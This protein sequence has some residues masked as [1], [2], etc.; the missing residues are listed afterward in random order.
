MNRAYRLVWSDIH[1]AFV[2]VA[3]F[4]RARGKRASSAVLAAACLAVPLAPT[5]AANLPEGGRIVAGSGSIAQSGNTMTVSQ[6][7]D[8]MAADW[9]SFSIGQGYAVN[10]VQPSAS[11]IA[12]NRVLGSDVSRIQGSLTA[13]GQVFLVNPNG[14]LFTPTARVEVGGLVASTRDLSVADF[15]AGNY[16]FSGGGNA[17]IRNEGEIKVGAGGTAAFIAAKIENVGRIEAPKGN[18]LMAAADTVRLDLGGPLKLEVDKGALDALIE[19]GGAILADGGRVL[20]TAQAADEI[21]TAVI[22]HTGITEA[23]TLAT[24][25]RGEI[26]L[27]ADMKTGQ[28][29]VGGRLD[30]SAPAGGDGGFIETSAAKVKVQDGAQVKAGHWLIDPND[31]TIAAS[32]GDITGATLSSSLNSGNVTIQSANGGTAGNGDIFV[33]DDITWTSGNTLTLSAYRNIEILSTID[34]SGGSGGKV[35]LE[36]GQ[37]AS[38]SGNTA[39]YSFGLTGSG[40]TGKINLQPGGNFSTRLGSDGSTFTWT[41]ITQ[42]GNAGDENNYT[43]NSLQGLGNDS[44]KDGRYVL[45]AD[46]DASATSTWN[47]GAGFKPLVHTTAVPVGFAARF[48]GLGHT[49]T[50]LTINRPDEDNVGLFSIVTPQPQLAEKH[51]RVRN[52]GLV[53]SSVTGNNTVGGLVGKVNDTTSSL[54]AMIRNVYADGVAVTGTDSVG[55]LVGSNG[56]SG[57]ITGSYAT[58][59]VS[60]NTNVGGLV[61]SNN[62]GTITDSYATGSVSG[63]TNVGGLVGSNNRGTITDSYATGIVTG[64]IS[65]GGLVGKNYYY[66]TITGSYATGIV[67][68]DF[69]VGGLVGSNNRSTVTDSY[70]TGDVTGSG[71]YVG[72]LV[73]QNYSAGVSLDSTISNS[74]ATG[75]VAGGSSVGGLVGRNYSMAGSNS[76]ISNSY[77]TGS[78]SGSGNNVGGLVGENYGDAGGNITI[79]DSY[80]TGSVSGSSSVGGLVGWNYNDATV[81]SSFWNTETSGQMTSAGGTGKTTAEM[82]T[83]ST[84]SGWNI[85]DA[86][87]TGTVWRIYDGD[88]YPLLR[89]ALTP[90]TIDSATAGS[91]VYDG[92]KVTTVPAGMFSISGSYDSSKILLGGDLYNQKNA[93]T[94]TARIYSTQDGYDLIGTRSAGYEITRKALTVSGITADSKTYDGTTDATV[95]YSDANFVGIISGDTLNASGA[96]ADKNVGNGKTVTLSFG[97]ADAGNYTFSGQ[98]SATADITPRPVSLTGSRVYDGTNTVAAAIFTLDNLVSGEDLTLSGSGAVDNKNVGDNKPV[99]LG[100]LAL[101]NGATGSATNYTL[102]G[103]THTASITPKA[104][105]LSGLTANDKTY[106]GTTAATLGSPGTLSGVIVTDDVSLAGT[107]SASF[108]DKN[109]GTGKTV[110]VSGLS[111]TGTD[112]GNYTLGSGATTTASIL[113]KALT[114]SYTAYSKTYDGTTAAM[115]TAT[116][117]DIIGSDEV[118][119]TANGAFADKNAAEDKIVTITGG[120]L[121][122]ADAGNYTLQNTTGTD[123]ADITRKL[124]TASYTAQNKTYDGTTT[125]SVSATS[126]DIIGSDEVHI[127]ASGSFADKNAGNGK[128]VNISGGALSG[129]DAG[130]YYLTNTTGTASADITPKALSLSGLTAHDKTYDGTTAATLGSLGT[131]SGVIGADAVSLAGAASASFADKNA[132]TGKTVTVSGLALTGTDAGNYTLGSGATTTASILPKALTASYTAYSKTYDGTTA[133]TVTATSNDIVAGDVVNIT[134]SGSFADKNA[135]EDKVVTI[136]GGA[137]SGA[138][139]GNYTLQ[140]TTGTNMADITRKV[141]TASYSAS[142]KVYDGTTAATV[143]GTSGDIVTGDTV[144]ITASGAFADKNAGTNKTVNVTGGALAGAD[145]GNYVL[146]NTTGT[147]SADITPKALSLSGLTANDKTYDGTTAATLSSLGTLA[148]VIGGDDVSV[149]GT[150]SASFADKNAG[151]GKTVT[152]SGLALTG[153]D[154]GNYTLGSG[155]TTTASILPKALTASYTA[156]SKTYDGTTAATVT[157]TSNDIVAGDVVNITASGSFADK[158]AAEDKVVTITGGALSGADAGNYTLQNT[159]GTNMADITRKVLT[160]SYSASNKVYDGTT[161]ATVSATSG[162]IVT[163]DTVDIT[164][165]GAFADKNAGTNKTVNVTGGALAGAD[166]GNYVLTNTTGTASADITPK[167]LSL[168]GL[169][170]NDKTYDGTTAATLSSLGTLAGVIGG[171]DVSVSGTASASFADKNAGTGKT[172]TV[173]GLA[174]TGTDAGNYTLGSGATTTASILPKA[175]TIAGSSA[176]DKVYDGTTTASVTAGTLSGFVGSETVTVASATGAFADKNTGTNKNVTASYT[177]ADGANGGLASNYTLAGET[178]QASITPKALTASYT[179]ANKVYDGTTVA[180]V[181]ATSGDIVSGDV[182]NIAASGSFDTKNVGTGKTVSIT[183]GALA[184]ADAGNYSLQNTT[185]TASADITP[186]PVVVTADA[187]NKTAGQPDPALTYSTGCAAGQSTD[188]GLVTGESLAGSLARDP[189]EAVGAYAI[190]QGTVTDANNPNYAIAYVGA[191]LTITAA[192]SGGNTGGG[193]APLD[194]ALASVQTTAG[195]D[196]G[197]TGTAGLAGGAPTGGGAGSGEDGGGSAGDGNPQGF[198]G[199]GGGGITSPLPGLMVIAGGIRLPEGILPDDE[200]WRRK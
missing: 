154:A 115:V 19:Q 26:L 196:S 67:T 77:A 134:A 71:S 160:A 112:A 15:M 163:G 187:K 64:D 157:A 51:E 58:G 198:A 96:F 114:A 101:G 148:G 36:Y 146:T 83:L 177:L 130:N 66:G 93:G 42:L 4:A 166:A 104:L 140:N 94:Y 37:G 121:S 29:N 171:D 8:R 176:A 151:T 124:L 122:G 132:G 27:L 131:L 3:E 89:W 59:I 56:N 120:A 43:T 117:S 45:G 102:T 158:N 91:K 195:N 192:S 105:S 98:V 55:G 123:T 199:A 6:S 100:S 181:S 25:E 179:A 7:T 9:Q 170:A 173:S 44:K 111:L 88:S 141:L 65:V 38:A 188:C 79:T 60:G 68:G 57:T 147:A 142:N 136:T 53:G 167:A 23:K 48:D 54:L 200:E 1:Q 90:L 155:A 193:G 145:A 62:S 178:L 186:R 149:S 194:A 126:S 119:I 63:N 85:D 129:T 22:N 5:F 28:A 31:F 34:A 40:F 74:Y 128:T 32:G 164:A 17:A 159:T 139:A 13:N 2:A 97:G 80:A 125:A 153:T 135:A 70:A 109:A 197:G 52:V 162:D 49:I 72:G 103:G 82:K 106:D 69:S 143:S 81:E 41:V 95:N 169:T 156:Y 152:V 161:A 47:G 99:T 30:A 150:A 172:V 84:F 138:D 12:L 39:T 183:G 14:V 76:I 61:G 184:G 180:T 174:L 92:N 18:V 35:A 175:L 110:T 78:V 11:S 73:G 87:G 144:D 24:G 21:A 20:L 10:F 185:G 165:S 33:K 113:P 133:A 189:G 118:N 46:I 116:S 190:R 127:T 182:V 168:S 137:L 50:N 191:D 86:G 16:R 108:A 107:A 75:S